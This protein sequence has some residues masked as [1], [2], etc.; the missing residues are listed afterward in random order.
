MYCIC[1]A[2]Y[3]EMCWFPFW[4]SCGALIPGLQRK[5]K[6]DTFQFVPTTA[7]D[8]IGSGVKDDYT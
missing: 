1:Y 2:K 4:N 5:Y 3:K 8:K 7:T 6:K